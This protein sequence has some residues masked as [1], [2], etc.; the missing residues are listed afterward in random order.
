MGK[1]QLTKKAPVEN[2]TKKLILAIFYMSLVVLVLFGLGTD[3]METNTNINNKST[4]QVIKD[5]MTNKVL[6]HRHIT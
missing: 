4:N 3:D 1:R 2:D 6:S 5:G